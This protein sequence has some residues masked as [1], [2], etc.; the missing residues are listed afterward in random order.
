[1]GHGTREIIR[2]DRGGAVGTAAVVISDGVKDVGN[3]LRN[4]WE[5]DGP[6]PVALQRRMR[7]WVGCSKRRDECDP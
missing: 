5:A 4:G 2:A 1:L 3:T 7:S 6:I